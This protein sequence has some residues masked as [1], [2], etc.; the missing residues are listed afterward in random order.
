MSGQC[1]ACAVACLLWVSTV[2]S[3]DRPGDGKRYGPH[4]L[5]EELELSEAQ[6]ERLGAALEEQRSSSKEIKASMRRI[7]DAMKAELAKDQPSQE[8]LEKTARES[9][10]LAE[11]MVKQRIAYLLKVKKILSR[12]QFGELLDRHWLHRRHGRSKGDD[13][14]TAGDSTSTP[15]AD[16]VQQE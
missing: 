12:E 9:G 13:K 1:V 5:L 2:F 14:R 10:E 15:A 7:R 3:G 4:A 6:R 8:A 11:Q 16:S